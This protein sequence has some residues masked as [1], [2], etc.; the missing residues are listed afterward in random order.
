MLSFSQNPDLFVLKCTSF[1]L[2]LYRFHPRG[3][4]KHPYC[5]RLI[6]RTHFLAVRLLNQ[7]RSESN[8]RFFMKSNWIRI[9]RWIVAA[10]IIFYGGI[11][12]AS[13]NQNISLAWDAS[14]SSDVTGYTV[15]YSQTGQAQTNSVNV[16]N[17]TTASISNLVE[18]ASYSFY[19]T[20]YTMDGLESQP[21]NII[22]YSV[23]VTIVPTL[24]N[25]ADQT[26]QEGETLTLTAN[27]SPATNVVFSLGAGAPTGA[28]IDPVTGTLTWTP[29]AAQ[30][31]SANII[32]IQIALIGSTT[33]SDIKS[34]NVTVTSAVVNQAP[35]ARTDKLA[36]SATQGTKVSVA[37]LLANDSDP[38][39]DPLTITGVS[40]TTANGA[41]VTQVGGL[42]FYIPNGFTGPDSFTYTVS[43][44]HGGTATGTVLVTILTQSQSVNILSISALDTG[45]MRIKVNGTPG[46][47]YVVQYAD[48]ATPNNWTVLGSVTASALGNNTI[49]DNSAVPMRMY[50]SVSSGN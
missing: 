8:L 18:G 46:R 4:E 1:Y 30:A 21:S 44:G 3:S 15:Y 27:S 16:G 33:I 31:P 35:I 43:D 45:A 24:S 20:A 25:I 42:I 23:P 14:A 13:G 7:I 12:S 41:T 32:T 11:L 36:R 34:F 26:L 40:S 28:V 39:S 37:A 22:T 17:F 47:T 6:I 49:D 9:G 48:F 38:D 29:S 5:L 2:R 50:R 10:S 19:V